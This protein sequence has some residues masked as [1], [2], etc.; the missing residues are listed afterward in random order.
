MRIDVKDIIVV[1]MDDKKNINVF[2]DIMK[3]NVLMDNKN[4]WLI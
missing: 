4:G 3:D 1:K 2:R